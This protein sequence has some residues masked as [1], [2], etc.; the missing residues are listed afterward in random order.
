M[1]C[2]NDLR[3]LSALALTAHVVALEVLQRAVLRDR[4][5]KYTSAAYID[6]TIAKYGS[7]EN[8]QSNYVSREGKRTQKS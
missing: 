6:K 8:L 7:L 1:L 4:L 5:V 3:L 2:Q